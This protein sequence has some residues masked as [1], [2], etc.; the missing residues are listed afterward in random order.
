MFNT[1]HSARRRQFMK[2][3]GTLKRFPNTKKEALEE[4]FP[5]VKYDEVIRFS[6]AK[7]NHWN[8]HIDAPE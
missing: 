7:G 5:L 4:W 2:A 6:K 3:A 8:G 1:Y